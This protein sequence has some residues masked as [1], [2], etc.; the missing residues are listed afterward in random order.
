MTLE[1]LAPHFEN[2]QEI[3]YIITKN[4][5]DADELTQSFLLYVGEHQN[6]TTVKL[7]GSDWND[8]KEYIYVSMRNM[9]G[10]MKKEDSK[11]LTDKAPTVFEDI[12]DP[13]QDGDTDEITNKKQL[14]VNAFITQG[15][16][17]NKIIQYKVGLLKLHMQGMSMQQIANQIGL[18]KRHVQTSIEHVRKIIRIEYEAKYG[19][20]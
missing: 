3:A 9:H 10:K 16:K 5:D 2:I 12:Y 17:Q 18:T 7:K 11:L 4:K 1:Q 13:W 14:F 20:E 15:Y 19:K 8:M 6:T